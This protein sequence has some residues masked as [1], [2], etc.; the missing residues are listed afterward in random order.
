MRRWHG[1]RINTDFSPPRLQDTK[2]FLT[3]ITQMNWTNFCGQSQSE[4]NNP[5]KLVKTLH[6]FAL[7]RQLKKSILNS[8]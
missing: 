2:K 7:H 6:I 5:H 4:F 1:G 3:L 8:S